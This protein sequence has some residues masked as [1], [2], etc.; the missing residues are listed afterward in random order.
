VAEYS[1]TGYWVVDR[2]N[3]NAEIIKIEDTRTDYNS[4]C[5][6]LELM[7]LYDQKWFPYVIS[8]TKF[9]IDLVDLSDRCVV[10][11]CQETNTS[12]MTPKLVV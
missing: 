3:E 1:K 8:R 9:K 6:N 4:G 7:P 2:N 11:L 12:G 5:T 10:T